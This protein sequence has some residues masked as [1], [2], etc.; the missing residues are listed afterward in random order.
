MHSRSLWQPVSSDIEL[1]LFSTHPSLI[2]E[3]DRAGI[4]GFIID[5]EDRNRFQRNH[6]QHDL[7]GPD[8]LKDLAQV[9]S[10]T[11]KPIWCRINQFGDWTEKEIEQAISHGA[12]LLLLP[13][14][15]SISEAKQFLELVNQRTQTGILVE[16]TEACELATKL[17]DL[18]LDRVYVGLFDLSISRGNNNLFSPLADGTVEQL[19][20]AFRDTRFGVGGL[21]TVDGGSP[22][23]CRELMAELARIG[24]DFTF[25]RN[26]FKRDLAERDMDGEIQAIRQAWYRAIARPSTRVTLEGA[27][28][29]AK[30]G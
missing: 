3:A 13:M 10:I 30:F 12:D 6:D 16:T 5:W 23:P 8:S 29:A 19:R 2:E 18:T 20:E 27:S 24:C 28:F 25:L 22:I 14:V 15:R 7:Q 11:N 17:A 4:D 21:T 1:L 9:S 26:S